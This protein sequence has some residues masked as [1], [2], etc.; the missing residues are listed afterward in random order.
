[1]TF[2]FRDN[3]TLQINPLS[4]TYVPQD[5]LKLFKFVGRVVALAVYHGRLVDGFF[6]RPFYKMML[7]KKITLKDMESV[8]ISYYRSLKYILEC[9]N[10][11]AMHLTFACDEEEFN[12]IKPVELIPGGS[13]IEVTSANKQTYIEALIKRKFV[14]RVEKQMNAF[15]K[16]FNEVVSLDSIKIFDPNEL[17]LLIC[18]LQDINVNDWKANTVYRGEYHAEHPVIV[19][20]WKVVYT[21]TNELRSRLLQFTTGTS[22]VPMNGFAELWGSETAQKFTIHSWGH[23]KQLPRSHTCFNRLDLPLYKT[24]D[25]LRTNL[26]VA[27]ENTEGFGGVD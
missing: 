26:I 13:K 2:V 6:I 16:G 8:D 25:E 20:F 14:S 11:E 18:G 27:I 10:V 22:R 19:N 4:E 24:F 23:V 9:K 21:F 17:E 12:K 7:G 5:H 3:Y 1:M 15:M